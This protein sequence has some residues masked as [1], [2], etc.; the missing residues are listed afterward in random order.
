MHQDTDH[1]VATS[2]ELVD[3]LATPMSIENHDYTSLSGETWEIDARTETICVGG[4]FDTTSERNFVCL[5]TR[6]REMRNVAQEDI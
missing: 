1:Y 5:C 2:R 6:C 3:Y 4:A